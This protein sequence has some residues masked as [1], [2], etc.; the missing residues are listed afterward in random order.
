MDLMRY[1]TE[2]ALL[3]LIGRDFRIRFSAKL[4][5]QAFMYNIWFLMDVVPKIL[6]LITIVMHYTFG[7]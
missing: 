6:V 5:N 2:V 3:I 4:R 7:N 1:L